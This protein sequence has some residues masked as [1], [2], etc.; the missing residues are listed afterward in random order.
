MSIRVQFVL[1]DEEYKELKAKA[2]KEGVSI[3]KYVKDRALE[4]DK[5][6]GF[7][8]IWDEFC[9]KLDKFPADVEFDVSAI[10]TQTRWKNFD[11]STKLSIARLFNKK[12]N[13]KSEGF[14]NIRIVGRSP[15]NVSKYMKVENS[16]IEDASTC[17]T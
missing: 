8:A 5:D 7:K 15:S 16:S 9:A 4:K 1:N 13:T 12:V 10:M 17:I 2:T 11:R 6:N 3:S 14:C